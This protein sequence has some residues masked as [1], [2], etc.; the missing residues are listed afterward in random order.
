VL[1]LDDEPYLRTV[2]TRMF[3]RLGYAVTAVGTGEEAIDA[4]RAAQ[5]AGTPFA[6]ALLDLTIPGAMGGREAIVELR[7]LAP[8]LL[9]I[10]SSGYSDDSVMAQPTLFGFTA[11][12]GKP[13]T[14][15]ELAEALARHGAPPPG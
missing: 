9:A 14:G 12:L 13:F 2:F 4:T 5:G 15:K 7:R 11:S 6:V 3:T 1:V 8:D 10:A